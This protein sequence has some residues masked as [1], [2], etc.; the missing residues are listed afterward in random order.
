MWEKF[1]Y[2]K[3]SGLYYF[4]CA[5]FGLLNASGLFLYFAKRLPGTFPEILLFLLITLVFSLI[6]L[7]CGKWLVFFDVNKTA[8]PYVPPKFYTFL[9]SHGFLAI[10]LFIFL[11][12]LPW[13]IVYYPAS[14]EW[15]TYNPIMQFLGMEEKTNHHPWFY[16]AMVG[17]F[18]K[19]GV[20]IGS[21][22]LGMFLYVLIRDVICAL[23]YGRIVYKLEKYGV[24]RLFCFLV[25]LFYAV[26][27][28]WGAYAKI[29]FK[30]T[31]AAAVFAMMIMCAIDLVRGID[32]QHSLMPSAFGIG[33]FG[34]LFCL[35]INNGI[36]VF[37]P[38]SILL[39]IA[40]A[41]RLRKEFLILCAF[42]LIFGVYHHVIINVLDVRPSSAQEVMAIPMQQ[43][44]RTVRDN[45]SSF[46]GEEL[47]MVKEY[48]EPEAI[49]GA[50]DPLISD[51]VK[52]I[53]V[54]EHTKAS[55][56]LKLWL[57]MGIR[58]P[59]S[60]LEALIAHSYGYYAF[61]PREEEGAGNLNT[62][63]TIFDWVKD[64][65][66]PDEFTCDYIDAFELPRQIL[67]KWAKIWD[68][69]P[70]IN[71]TDAIPLYTWLTVISGYIV[72][73]KKKY[74]EL[75]PVLAMLIM[76]ATCVAS[77]VNGCFRYFCPV[78]AALPAFLGLESFRGVKGE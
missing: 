1:K 77:P 24:N 58:Y 39:I 70:V 61:T 67:S 14:I 54:N 74:L 72:L 66:F 34:L 6:F 78:A 4:L 45:Y 23:L 48:A 32:A 42:L 26:T 71:L 5:L 10:A 52:S 30:N 9:S 18:Y 17:T 47:D 68:K 20:S 55:R 19:F 75:I 65:R 21:K 22:N 36:C 51:P 63:M 40:L 49:S 12:W 44:S 13:I 27:P 64:P 73:R 3:L 8:I 38:I 76:I 25:M 37:L 7:V 57:Y 69:I 50:Y 56:S 41:V 33:F 11:C 35:H 59:K 53:W 60:Y 29:A 43:L 16:A 46:T 31:F 2:R 62:G 15:D 28:V